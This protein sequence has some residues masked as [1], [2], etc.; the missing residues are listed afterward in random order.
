MD[1]QAQW[2]EHRAAALHGGQDGNS[3]RLTVAAFFEKIDALA[4][5][6]DERGQAILAAL[7]D[8][9]EGIAPEA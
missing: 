3:G 5:T 4:E 9:A 6:A 2:E 7:Y 1:E 8:W